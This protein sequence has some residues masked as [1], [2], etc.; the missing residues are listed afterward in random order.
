MKNFLSEKEVQI[1]KEHHR[2]CKDKRS[3][4]RIKTILYLNLGFSY[5]EIAELLMLDDSTVREFYNKYKE[6][7]IDKLLE[8]K[9]KGGKSRLSYE[10]MKALDEH[11]QEHTYTR[12]KDIASYIEKE[13]G[14]KYTTEGVK[15]LLHSLGYSYKKPKRVP[16]K[17][18]KEQQEKFLRKLED[19]KANKSAEDKIYYLDSVHPT[20]NSI[21]AYGWIKKGKEKLLKANS[22]RRRLN[23]N[24]AY[25][26]E[27]QK[28]IVCEDESI[29]ADST[30]ALIE[31][32]IEGQKRGKIY[33]ICD[34]ARYY[35]SKKVREFVK[36]HSRIEM[37]FLP[38][39]SPNLNLIERLWLF[40]KKRRL[41]NCYYE[42]FEEF[43]RMCMDFFKDI[44]LYKEE[45]K[46][47]MTENFRL[48]FVG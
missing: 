18:N 37:I 43:R 8:Y 2:S 11:L 36:R 41:W 33:L 30:I 1:L 48:S 3:A 38:P 10:Q 32:I 4:D 21:P 13:F 23:I 35:C 31:K 17:A 14:V 29:N 45:L 44:S 15:K 12:S 7:G 9:W 27:E 25:E 42:K 19:I 46:T 39:Y 28:V 6:G 40:F 22:G 20:H 26:P 47:L 5:E 24:G 16:G 34:N